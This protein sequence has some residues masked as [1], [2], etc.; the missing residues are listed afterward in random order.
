MHILSVLF[1]LNGRWAL[2]TLHDVVAVKN[3]SEG[4]SERQNCELPKSDRSLGLSGVTRR[5]GAVDDSPWTDRVSDI[6]GTVGERS[7]AGS[8]NLN[9]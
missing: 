1:H 3:E 8:E 9:E 2:L 5:P 7:S 6:V 4:D